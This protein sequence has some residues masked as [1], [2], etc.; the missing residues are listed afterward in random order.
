MVQGASEE[1]GS[2][3]VRHPEIKAVGFTGSLRAGRALHDIAAAREEPIT[4]YAEMGSINPTFVTRAALDARA[5]Q[6]GQGLADSITIANGQFCTK[7][8][9]VIVPAGEGV[10]RL[11]EAISARLAESRAGVL[12]NPRIRSELGRQAAELSALGAVSELAAG[13]EPD[14]AC[15]FRPAVHVTDTATF[16]SHGEL[17]SEHFGPLALVVTYDSGEQLRD[18]AAAV[19]NSLTGTIHAEP[20]DLDESRVLEHLLQPKVGRLIYNGFPTGVAVTHA[21]QHGGPYPATTAPWSTS[22]GSASIFRF[23]RPV[24]FQNFPAALLPPALRDEN[25]LHLLR[26]VNGDFTREPV[27]PT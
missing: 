1:V 21:M 11:G 23:M 3:L 27:A 10:G 17:R 26:L 25:P 19:P 14:G 2:E 13:N 5:E 12:L 20:S 16:L 9:V 15:S 22:V 4:V 6:I 18:V 24:T 7:P 8:G